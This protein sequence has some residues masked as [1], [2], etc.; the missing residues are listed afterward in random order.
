MN[1]LT[2]S[3]SSSS[4]FPRYPIRYINRHVRKF[5]IDHSITTPFILSTIPLENEY[6]FFRRQFLALTT[7]SEHARANRIASQLDPSQIDS[8][9]DPLVKVKLLKRLQKPN[10]LTIHYN[11]ERRFAH[12]KSRI[13]RFWNATFPPSTGIESK[14]IV[15]SRNNPNLTHEI[16]RRSPSHQVRE[17]RKK[18]T[19]A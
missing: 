5:F 18:N 19:I 4:G 11:Y 13:H 17:L 7:K 10:L 8:T 6:F 9:T 12:Y 16:V 2:P 1:V 3:S 15:G 14:L